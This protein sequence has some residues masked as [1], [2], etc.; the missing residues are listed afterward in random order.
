VCVCYV[1]DTLAGHDVYDSTTVT[2]AFRP[3]DIPS[4]DDAVGM[5]RGLS[6]G[7]PLVCVILSRHG[8]PLCG[9]D[10]GFVLI[11]ARVRLP[12]VPLS[13]LGKLFTH[14]C[15]CHQAV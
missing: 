13:T 2:D 14:M 12:A 3:V 15:L 5:L 1:A 4:A 7:I 6:V 9:H 8:S 11:L 10:S